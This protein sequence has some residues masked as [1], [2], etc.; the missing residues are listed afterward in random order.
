MDL[1]RY[2]ADLQE[3]VASITRSATPEVQEA[4]EQ[5][6]GSLQPALRL[7]LLEFASDITSD[8]TMQLDGDSVD[9]RIRGGQP[10]I[11]VERQPTGELP[12]APTPPAPPAPSGAPGDDGDGGYARITLRLPEHLKPRVDEAAATDE[13]SV[14][15]W[16]VRAV[17]QALRTRTPE[18][19]PAS[20]TARRL[21]GWA[22]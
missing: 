16:L 20:T 6:V 21:T 9:V 3:S 11:V 19:T 10:E 7:T 13:V 5:L 4:A 8:I 1:S 17:Q 15:T 14:N 2:L 18:P 22:R 12:T